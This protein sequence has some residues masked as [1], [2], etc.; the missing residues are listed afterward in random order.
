MA[1][2]KRPRRQW[3]VNP[4]FQ[5]QFAAVL[6]LMHVNIGFLYQVALHYRTRKLA[7]E[8]GSLQAYLDIEP[9]VSL[10]PA[11]LISAVIS[12][13]VV[14][15]IG[16]R[17]SNQIVGPLP[18]VTRALG[19]IAAG[20]PASHLKFRRGD[21]LEDLAIQVNSLSDSLYPGSGAQAPANEESKQSSWPQ[22]EAAPS[23]IDPGAILGETGDHQTV[24]P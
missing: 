12:G 7:E 15:Y 23:P 9:W 3:I 24:R 20:R 17:F 10:W 19:D 5:F 16:V 21:V 18:R 6:V 11:M 8:A 13:A 14:F 2:N 4:R 1:S 22:Q